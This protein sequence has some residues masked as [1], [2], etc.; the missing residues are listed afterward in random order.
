MLNRYVIK[1]MPGN[2]NNN[3]LAYIIFINE[4]KI[5]L[6]HSVTVTDNPSGG[7]M[8]SVIGPSENFTVEFKKKTICVQT[9]HHEYI[10]N[11]QPTNTTC[12]STITNSIEYNTCIELSVNYEKGMQLLNEFVENANRVYNTYTGGVSKFIRIV[13][14]VVGLRQK[15]FPMA[16]V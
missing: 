2:Y 10:V 15:Q 5:K 14:M 11:T 3:Y 6:K 1:Y 7:K 12:Q 8:E 9:Y 13:R 16:E 4:Y